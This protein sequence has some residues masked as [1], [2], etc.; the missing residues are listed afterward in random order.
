MP[1]TTHMIPGTH[2]DVS[3][4]VDRRLRTLLE[5]TVARRGIHHANV[6]ITS[7]DGRRWSGAAG[8]AGPDG[9]PLRPDTPFFVASV[10][11]RFIITLVLQ[12]Q[13]RGEIH[14]DD[15][16]TAH[17]PA[18]VADGLHVLRGVDHTGDVDRHAG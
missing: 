3:D 9:T 18:A 6:A 14:L 17:L 5:R 2:N 16:V 12:A 4:D 1:T 8:D 10:T 11:K 7:G 13:E 15:P